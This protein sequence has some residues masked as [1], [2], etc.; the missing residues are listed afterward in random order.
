MPH[1]RIATLSVVAGAFISLPKQHHTAV[2]DTAFDRF[3][4]LDRGEHH[5]IITTKKF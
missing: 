4:V 2:P 5:P 3:Y 1:R